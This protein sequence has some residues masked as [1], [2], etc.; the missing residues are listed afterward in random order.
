VGVPALPIYAKKLRTRLVDRKKE[1]PNE[2]S[3]LQKQ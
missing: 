1:S 2:I 3:V